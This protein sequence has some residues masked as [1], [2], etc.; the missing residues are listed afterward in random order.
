MEPFQDLSEHGRA[1]GQSAGFGECLSDEERDGR[2]EG[3]LVNAH[4]F[5][6]CRKAARGCDGKACCNHEHSGEID[7]LVGTRLVHKG[8]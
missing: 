7:G 3:A 1:G 2:T 8:E 6:A 5:A 4:D